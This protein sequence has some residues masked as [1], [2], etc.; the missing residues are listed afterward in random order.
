M[1]SILIAGLWATAMISALLLGGC[2]S[3]PP[4]TSAPVA[5]VTPTYHIGVGDQLQIY[6]ADKPNLSVTVPVGPD[7]RV[8]MPLVQDMSAEGKTPRQLAQDLEKKL[9]RYVRNPDVTVIVRSFHGTYSN[10]VR[11][12][13]QAVKPQ[14]LPYRAGMTLLDAMTAVG[15]LTPY[16]AGNR[17]EL[18]RKVDG[19]EMVYRAYLSDLLNGNMK[20]N[21]PLQPG[22]VIIIPQKLF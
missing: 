3:P 16:A 5:A 7:G 15:G 10:E 13:G 14:A 6:V 11:I 2:A 9:A 12:V 4:V 17:S 8:A 20:D 18:I 22:D 1:R 21:A 19:K